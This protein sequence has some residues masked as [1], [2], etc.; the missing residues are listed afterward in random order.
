MLIDRQQSTANLHSLVVQNYLAGTCFQA[1]QD[2]LLFDESNPSLPRILILFFNVAFQVAISAAHKPLHHRLNSL[3]FYHGISL[4][5]RASLR[6][7]QPLVDNR[8]PPKIT[9][10]MAMGH[11]IFFKCI[12]IQTSAF[13]G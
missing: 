6:V 2:V 13:F 4:V 7:L 10:S 5:R 12:M 9:H 8:A 11:H 3:F 1:S